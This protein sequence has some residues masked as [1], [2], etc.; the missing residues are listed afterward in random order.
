M[1]LAQ[2]I[3]T[4]LFDIVGLRIRDLQMKQLMTNEDVLENIRK[5]LQEAAII[6]ADLTAVHYVDFDKS[7]VTGKFYG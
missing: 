7:V 2:H 5:R 3:F 4:I 1:K 6:S